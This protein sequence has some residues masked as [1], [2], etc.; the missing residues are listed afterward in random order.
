MINKIIYG[1][2]VLLDLTADTVSADKVLKSFTCHDKSGAT[3]VGTCDFDSNTQS[4][5][6]S[7]AE[8]LENKTAFARGTMLTGTMP[9]NGG[10]AGEITTKSEQY[11][12]PQGYHDG[13]GKV[14]ISAT[15][16]AKIVAGN[17]KSGVTILGVEGTYSGASISAESKTVTPT[18]AG[19]TVQPTS[20]DYLS[21]VVVN[22]IPYVES[23]NSAGGTTVTIG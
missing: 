8:I 19:F 1:N 21:S 14:N 10:V 11:S 13:S 2:E 17:I 15:E 12:I 23:E 5:T 3:I 6:V 9:N 18:K 20:A 4:A 16:Q 7:V 22:P